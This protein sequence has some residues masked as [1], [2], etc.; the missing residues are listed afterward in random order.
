[1]KTSSTL[2]IRGNINIIN[3][4][5]DFHRGYNAFWIYE[6]ISKHK[7]IPPGGYIDYES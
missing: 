4:Y 3:K 1:M 5:S 6:L 7:R 2:H